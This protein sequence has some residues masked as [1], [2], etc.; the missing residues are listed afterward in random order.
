MEQPTG[1]NEQGY[2]KRRIP[3]LPEGTALHASTCSL[4]IEFRATAN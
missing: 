1:E 2:R 3:G 4:I